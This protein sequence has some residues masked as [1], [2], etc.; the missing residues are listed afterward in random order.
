MAEQEQRYHLF[1]YDRDKLG[2][3][4]MPSAHTQSAASVGAMARLPIGGGSSVQ[5]GSAAP[6]GGVRSPLSWFP[7]LEVLQACGTVNRPVH[8]KARLPFTQRLKAVRFL[9]STGN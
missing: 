6:T 7:P 8:S 1:R 4:G 3:R 5:M 2:L 9:P